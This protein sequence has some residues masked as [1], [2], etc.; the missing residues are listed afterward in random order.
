MD[1]ILRI[2]RLKI[3]PNIHSLEENLQFFVFGI[4]LFTKFQ[5][6]QRSR[7]LLGGYRV[8]GAGNSEQQAQLIAR[9]ELNPIS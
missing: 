9:R 8:D 6:R 2:F 7:F 3:F 1:V 5:E 4:I